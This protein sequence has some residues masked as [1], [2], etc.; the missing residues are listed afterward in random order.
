LVDVEENSV[1]TDPPSVSHRII[2]EHDDVTG[3]RISRHLG[4]DAIEAAADVRRKPS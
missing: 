3:E 2:S 4:E 1:G